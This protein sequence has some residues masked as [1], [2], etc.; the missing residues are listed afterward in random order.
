VREV[1]RIILQV[2]PITSPCV[3]IHKRNVLKMDEREVAEAAFTF[4]GRAP[5]ALIMV[6]VGNPNS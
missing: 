6:V 3:S 2:F 4:A 5:G 1:T